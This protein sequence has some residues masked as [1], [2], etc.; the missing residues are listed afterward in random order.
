MKVCIWSTSFQADTL[1]LTLALERDSSI[2]LLVATRNKAAMIDEPI[3]RIRP[4]DA[5]VNWR[6]D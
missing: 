2:E 5:E 6:T 4:I 3:S 1:A